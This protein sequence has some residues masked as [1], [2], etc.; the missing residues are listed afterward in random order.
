MR[1]LITGLLE[2]AQETGK[3]LNREP[4]DLSAIANRVRADLEASE[5]C[6]RVEWDIQ[7]GVTAAGDPRLLEAALRNLLGNAWKYSSRAPAPRIRFH[8]EGEAFCVSDNGAG[9]PMDQAER[10]FQPF[11]RL[12][13][14]DQFPGL[15]IGLATVKRIIDRHGGTLAAQGEVGRGATFRFTLPREP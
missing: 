1:D 2:M 14:S 13:A 10:L 15:G 5:P 7:P 9:F 11:R 12:H 4:V 8:R 3:P 6:R